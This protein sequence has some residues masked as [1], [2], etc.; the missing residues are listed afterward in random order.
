LLDAFETWADESSFDELDRIPAIRGRRSR[1][2]RLTTPGARRARI[3]EALS[4]C[5][6]GMWIA[7]EDFYRAIKIWHFDFNLEEGD[8]ENLYIGYGK[9][10]IYHGW[11]DQADQWLLTRGL[12]INAILWEYLGAIGALDL[13]YLHPEDA[14]FPAEA[15]YF[16]DETYYSRYDGLKYFRINSLGA[17]LF[18]QA[19]VYTPPQKES[20]AY[21]SVTEALQIAVHEPLALTPNLRAQLAQIAVDEG[22]GRYRLDTQL[23]LTALADGHN[24]DDLADLL[25]QGAGGPLPPEVVAWFDEVKTN[26][27]AFSLG[28]EA[29]FVKTETAAL[30]QMALADPTLGKFC[31]LL[32]AKTLIVPA[33]RTTALRNRL[34]ELGYGLKLS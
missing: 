15:Y 4:W 24:A 30:A 28:G 14:D 5:P 10:V 20:Q 29:Y 27:Q 3:I 13:L 9:E 17:Y 18:G 16:D 34:K 21:Y 23:L 25:A 31:R 12:Y 6:V 2:I 26:S 22:G 8:E 1:N 11:A 32:D 33:N 19:G 7:V